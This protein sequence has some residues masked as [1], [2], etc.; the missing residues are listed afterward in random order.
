MRLFQ[1]LSV[2]ALV[3]LTMMSCRTAQQSIQPQVVNYRID[4]TMTKDSSIV[5]YYLPFKQQ[6][7]KE[8]NRQIGYSNHFLNKSR[9]EP[10]FLAGNFFTDAML[11]VAK[12]IDP[13]VQIAIATKGGIRAELKQGPITV[14]SIFEM[15]PFENSITILELKGSDILVLANYIAK[16][17][18]QPISGFTL[19]IKDENPLD[20]L[21]EGKPIHPDSTYKLVT[22][23][24][25]A[26]GG[27]YIVGISNPIKRTNTSIL[28]R[29]ALIEYVQEL[30][31]AGKNVNTKLDG[32]VTIIK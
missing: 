13:S 32:R 12:K 11:S 6:M 1:N 9:T 23:D 20:I 28:V 31:K 21:I 19:K 22:Y 17:G 4:S 7:E 25:L 18:G 30:T 5:H 8:M 27:D 10:E 3:A 29:T 26:N 14:G 2:I 15:M 24:Y 16:T